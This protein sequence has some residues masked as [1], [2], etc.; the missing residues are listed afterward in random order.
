MIFP[1]VVLH[2]ILIVYFHF[3]CMLGGRVHI[4]MKS[5]LFSVP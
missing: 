3:W 5:S 2:V 1:L 4:V